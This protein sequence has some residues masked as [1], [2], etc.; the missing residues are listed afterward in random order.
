MQRGQARAPKVGPQSKRASLCREAPL[1]LVWWLRGQDLN[2]RPSGYEPD[3]LPGCSTPRHWVSGLVGARWLVLGPGGGPCGRSRDRGVLIRSGGD[4]LSR[5]LRC[6]TIG[7]AA[8]NGRVR[9]G[10]GCIPAPMAAGPDQSPPQTP[11]QRPLEGA[12]P[13]PGTSVAAPACPPLT[14]G[15]RAQRPRRARRGP[16]QAKGRMSELPRGRGA[17][18]ALPVAGSDPAYRTISTGQLS[19]LPRLHLRPIDVVVCHGPQGDL[20]SRGASRLDAF[21]GYPVRS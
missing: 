10:I 8:L 1:V 17:S 18:R 20:V 16:F 7:G 11:A 4:L 12:P 5:T 15:D 6:S 9:D 19:A 14:R 21:S 2:L 13:P 3:E